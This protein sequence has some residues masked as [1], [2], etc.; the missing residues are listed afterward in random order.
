MGHFA[1]LLFIEN[2]M[3][4]LLS[5]VSFVPSLFKWIIKWWKFNRPA[6]KILGGMT[7]NDLSLNIF[8]KDLVVPQNTSTSPKLF[9][10]E[11]MQMQANP[12]IVKVWPEVEAR[13]LA[14]ILNLLGQLDKK[15][16]IDLVEMSKGYDEWD[17]NLIVLGAQALK[18]R[19]FYRIMKNVGYSMD[20]KEI[21]D[22]ENNQPINKSPEYGYGLIIKAKNSAVKGGKGVG[23]LLGGFGTLGTESAI[24]Y[25]CKNIDILGK[26]FGKN[27]FSVVVRARINSGR[28]SVE[29]LTGL[30]KKFE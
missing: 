18:S 7:D 10:Q 15:D 19:E 24:Y 12:N 26:K 25:F 28:E 17:E 8:V 3:D 5:F 13:G 16:K 30:D 6:G 27:D 21:Y 2:I 23:I 1:L 4:I 14:E 22:T 11:G 20:E 9:S 29:R